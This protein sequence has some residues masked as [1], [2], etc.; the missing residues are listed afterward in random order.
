MSSGIEPRDEPRD[1][2]DSPDPTLSAGAHGYRIDYDDL[3]VV[4]LV[5]QIRERVSRADAVGPAHPEAVEERVRGRLRTYLDLDERRPYELEKELGLV[6]T[7]NVR[8]EDLRESGRRGLGTVVRGLRTVARPFLKLVANFELPLY[9]QFKINLG[10]AEAVHDLL[11][12]NA[13][14]RGRV[15]ELARR[16]ER[17]EAG[18]L[19]DA[20]RNA[21]G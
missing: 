11:R 8:P 16:V 13:E 19:D 18:S 3:D 1:P 10:L 7:W 20:D 15:E 17:L 12:E 14:L 6:G 2:Q 21:P 9:K 4:D 5:R